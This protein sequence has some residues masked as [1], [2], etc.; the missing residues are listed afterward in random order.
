MKEKLS[1]VVE[2]TRNCIVLYCNTYVQIFR[3]LE[4]GL[5]VFAHHR[6]NLGSHD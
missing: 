1:Y 2:L 6:H 4:V 5:N 3:R